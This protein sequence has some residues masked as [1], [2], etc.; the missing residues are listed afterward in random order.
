[1]TSFLDFSICLVMLSVVFSATGPFYSVN[2]AQ[3]DSSPVTAGPL[4]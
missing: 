1:V 2:M 3:P 4:Q